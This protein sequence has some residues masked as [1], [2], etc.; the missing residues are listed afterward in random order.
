M[1]FFSKMFSTTSMLLLLLMLLLTLLSII[2]D[3]HY[4]SCLLLYRC[5]KKIHSEIE[6]IVYQLKWYSPTSFMNLALLVLRPKLVLLLTN[7]LS[8]VSLCFSFC[9]CLLVLQKHGVFILPRYRKSC[10][11]SHYTTLYMLLF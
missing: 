11:T 4:N 3:L 6:L 8:D 1:C 2:T 10:G 7:V 9:F 5:K